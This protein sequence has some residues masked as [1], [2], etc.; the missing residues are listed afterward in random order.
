MTTKTT[1][2]LIALAFLAHSCFA[3]LPKEVSRTSSLSFKLEKKEVRVV[4][5]M[6]D[7]GDAMGVEIRSNRPVNVSIKDPNGSIRA[8]E[9]V[10]GK[11]YSWI[12]FGGIAGA[13][14]I[15]FENLLFFSKAELKVVIAITK[16]NFIYGSGENGTD[17]VLNE[18]S[19]KI[20]TSGRFR[21]KKENPVNFT[22]NALKG[23]TF[24]VDVTPVSGKCPNISITNDAGEWLY[25]SLPA[26]LENVVSVP[27]LS[28]GAYDI[29]IEGSNLFGFLPSLS[30]QVFDIEIKKNS[31]K[32][33][34]LVSK[35]EI[36][37]EAETP[38]ETVSAVYLDTIIF[39]GATRD[40]LNP[41][42]RVLDISFSDPENI[43]YW[44]IIYGS[45]ADF[46]NQMAE[47]SESEM[48]NPK[49]GAPLAPLDAYAQGLLRSL[50][51]SSN[52]EISF[53][54]SED[55][56]TALGGKNYGRVNFFSDNSRLKMVNKSK[57]VGRKAR[58]RVLYFRS[59]E[60]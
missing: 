55:I 42:E 33:Y 28:D 25:A 35:T 10:V 5:V 37:E 9:M 46:L 51:K 24:L 6:A 47:L 13:W 30:K 39:L 26:R 57:S 56:A 43:L 12:D 41:N 3:Q 11:S 54:P 18:R 38:S 45:G 4:M 40:I 20:I 21:V 23:D 17:S 14:E 36:I 48:V 8:G 27:A 58:V 34:A 60:E 52:N 44:V 2:L 31:P 19:K 29:V 49:T 22:V 15:T 1:L 59:I 53:I 50:P 7:S 16:P 32:R